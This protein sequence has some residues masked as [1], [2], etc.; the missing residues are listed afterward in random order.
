MQEDLK[1]I[2]E[3]DKLEIEKINNTFKKLKKHNKKKLDDIFHREDE[4]VFKK[5]DC[6]TCANC[7]KTTSP[8]FRDID[9]KRLSKRFRM[10]TNAFV[11]QYLRVDADDDYVLKSSPCPF[12]WDNNECSVYE[13]RPLACREYPHTNRKNMYQVLDLAKK[14]TEVCPAV[15]KIIENIGQKLP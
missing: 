6:L 1:S 4:A 15:V 7:C 11:S 13:D 12:L 3:K 5:I 2:L 14:N 10:K 9:V 8:I